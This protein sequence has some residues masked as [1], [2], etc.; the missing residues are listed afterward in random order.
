MRKMTLALILAASWG[1][2]GIVAAQ[3]RPTTKD[4][5]ACRD[6]EDRDVCYLQVVSRSPYSTVPLSV[7]P[8]YRAR[9]DLVAAIEGPGQ[10]N[11]ARPPEEGLAGAYYDVGIKPMQEAIDAGQQALELDREGVSPAEALAPI[12]ALAP[13]LESASLML[14]QVTTESGEELRIGQYRM[15]VDLY[16]EEDDDGLPPPSEGLVRAALAA[17]EAEVVEPFLTYTDFSRQSNMQLLASLYAKTGD[18][19]SAER[20][21]AMTDLAKEDQPLK[22]VALFDGPA[23]AFR[24]A[25]AEVNELPEGAGSGS[26]QNTYFVRRLPDAQSDELNA[27]INEAVR[28]ESFL[29]RLATDEVV[30]LARVMG[31][32]A[33]PFLVAELDRRGVEEPAIAMASFWHRLGQE[34]RVDAALAPYIAAL[35]GCE[36]YRRCGADDLL[37]MLAA[38][39]RMDQARVIFKAPAAEDFLNRNQFPP[40]DAEMIVG[41]GYPVTTDWMLD[42]MEG[43]QRHGSTIYRLTQCMDERATQ[44]MSMIGPLPPEPEVALSCGRLVAEKVRQPAYIAYEQERLEQ[45]GS[46]MDDAG[47]A[48]GRYRVATELFNFAFI[49]VETRPELAAEAEALALELFDEAPELDLGVSIYLRWLAERRL[50]AEGRL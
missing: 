27:A 33:L 28:S 34:E 1:C 24:F 47:V 21:F 15:I 35:E 18:R 3:D 20:V 25:A 2:A 48:P 43:L 31:D 8:E 7:Y 42:V 40:F 30:G 38:S 23:A 26:L 13:D 29:G 37:R 6:A 19:A 11:V 32:E 45:M 36:D 9:P 5:V 10:E 4:V 39:G 46:T 44:R 16:L 49:I 22:K 14:G 17:W 50:R 12:R 41:Q